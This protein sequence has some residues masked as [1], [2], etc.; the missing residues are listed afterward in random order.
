M[1]A[2]IEDFVHLGPANWPEAKKLEIEPGDLTRFAP[3]GMGLGAPMVM[4]P[5]DDLSS[6]TSRGGY[7]G[8]HP[9]ATHPFSDAPIT[10]EGGGTIYFDSGPER[11]D[12][13]ALLRL[14]QVFDRMT[15]YAAFL[16]TA[17]DPPRERF[18]AQ[19]R[20]LGE[21]GLGM[22]GASNSEEARQYVEQPTT[23]GEL[24]WKFVQLQQE[25]WLGEGGFSRR[26]AWRRWRLG[27]GAAGLRIDG[28]KR[29]SRHLP[30][31]EPALADYQVNGNGADADFTGFAR[32]PKML[33]IRVIREI[34]GCIFGIGGGPL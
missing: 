6:V 1:A 19:L 23:A 18:L 5:W 7:Y 12:F 2:R 4:L 32:L 22:Y 3:M 27:Q 15:K 17:N 21:S 31:L 26:N 25:Y 28:R 16:G 20:I 34:R 30:D 33:S 9:H 24:L 8:L 10:E 11:S 29:L 14:M 13:D